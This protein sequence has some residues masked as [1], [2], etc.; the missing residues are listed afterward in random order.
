MTS[1]S[2]TVCMTVCAVEC[3]C[4]DFLQFCCLHTEFF[5]SD[6]KTIFTNVFSSFFIFSKLLFLDGI[7]GKLALSLL[8]NPGREVLE[9][10]ILLP[11]FSK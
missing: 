5:R 2:N 1:L 8:Y 6:D 9:F 11:Q 3:V 4:Q 10:V 7:S